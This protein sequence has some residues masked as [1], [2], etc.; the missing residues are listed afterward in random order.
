MPANTVGWRDT[1]N[2]P[3]MATSALTMVTGGEEIE[4]MVAAPSPAPKASA[5]KP[6]LAICWLALRVRP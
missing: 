2:A 5:M 4:T 6:V 1:A 3:V